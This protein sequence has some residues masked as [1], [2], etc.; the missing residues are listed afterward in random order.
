[1]DISNVVCVCQ[2]F[3]RLIESKTAVFEF[4]FG[5]GIHFA[6]G[7]DRVDIID[8]DKA[9]TGRLCSNIFGLNV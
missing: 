8:V 2:V 1:M 4:K 3:V 6:R 5:L 7:Q 9:R